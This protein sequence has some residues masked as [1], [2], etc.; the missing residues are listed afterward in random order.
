MT[1]RT[2]MMIRRN[3]VMTMQKRNTSFFFADEF[4]SFV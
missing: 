1:I 3:I 4:V 2:N